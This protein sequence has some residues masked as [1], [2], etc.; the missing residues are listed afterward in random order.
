[1][2]VAA[3]PNVATLT[4]DTKVPVTGRAVE[5]MSMVWV[6]GPTSLRGAGMASVIPNI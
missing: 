1:M 4:R 3:P 5:S 2:D 6:A